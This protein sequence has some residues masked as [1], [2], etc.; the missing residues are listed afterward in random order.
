MTPDSSPP[1][2]ELLR[3][4]RRAAGLTQ[5]ELAERAGLSWRGINDLER[6]VRQTPRKDTVALLAAALGL[7][8][9]ERTAFEVAARRG[10][11]RAA[12]APSPTSPP[13]AVTDESAAPALPTGTVTFLFTDIEGST[14]LLQQLGSERY[15][16][17]EA[18]HH[19]V[20][21]AACAAHSGREV[22]TAGDSFFVAFARAAEAVAVA[23]QAQR[24]LA[25]HAWPEGAA[26]RVRMGLH[27][28]API[29][30][31][32]NYVGLDVH[33]AARIAAAGHGGQVLLSQTTRDLVEA[34]LPEGA[35]LRDLGAHRLK[36]L[37]RP[38]QLSQLVLPDLPADFPPLNALD[39]H[40]HNLPVQLTS[41][42]GRER[43]LAEL[44]PLLLA[45]RLL[46]LTG[47]GGTGKT[48]LALSLAADVLERFADGVWLVEL[49]PLADP[50]LVPHSVA[51]TL[52]V[53]EQ[54]G[55]PILET[56]LDALRP[57]TLLLL[58]DNCE[59]LI[60]T[61][62]QMAETLLRAAPSVR[63]LASSR[64]ALGIAGETAYRV[65][66]LPLPDPVQPGHQRALDL[67]ALAQ[68]DCVRLFVERAAATY[69]SFRLT[70]TNAR[71]IAQIGRR[72]DGIP[73]A[74]ELAAART[75]VF[76]PNQIVARLDDR[77]RLLTGGSRTALPR[78]QTLLALI[79]WSHDLLSEAE[80][81]LL[82]RLSVFAGGWSLEAAQAVCGDGLGEDVL[83]MLANIAEKS[84]VEVDASLDA[85]EARYRFLET[86]RQ[87]ARDKLLA[88]GEAEQVR[89]RHLE[90]FVQFAEEAEPRLRGAEQLAWL[91]R[92]EQ[93]HDNLRTA[94]AWAVESGKRERALRLAGALYYFWEL[95][96]YWSEG[97][98]W[99]DDALALS[100]RQQRGPAAAGA[101]GESGI[102]TRGE[103]ALRAKALYGAARMHFGAQLDMADSRTLVE[104]SLRLWREL[105]DKWWTAVALEHIAFVLFA[106]D[107][108]TSTARVEEGVSLAREVEDRW[109]LA[110]CL[111]RLAYAVA[112]T[113]V[114]AAWR[115]LEEWV[116][117]ARGVGDKSVLSMGLGGMAPFY[118]LEGNLAAAASAA[119]EALG[120]ARAIGSVVQVFLSLFMLIFTACLQGDLATA[121]EY[122]V[123]VVAYTRETGA[124]QWLLLGLL[125]FGTVACFGGQAE[126][127]VRLL[128][129][130]ETPMR[131]RGLDPSKLGPGFMVIGQALERARAQLGPAFEL[132][133]AEGQQMTLEQA[134]ALAT[135]D[136]S[137]D[138]PLPE[139]S[140]GPDTD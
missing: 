37:Q 10:M 89:D 125:G 49:A 91:E 2:G 69:I 31:G 23:A 24:A 44:T 42:V 79:D 60:A 56:L 15:A 12:P 114:A 51:A 3:R 59:H 93:E 74:L 54:P 106:E 17:L 127:G 75:R 108:Q 132:A 137:V 66:S 117:V 78:H 90:Y 77:F 64:E 45:S 100:A 70:A 6:G 36:D 96:G 43:E 52:G 9:E 126:R 130:A 124:S 7:S 20:V 4:S 21:R 134:L 33:R 105:D 135:D 32:D 61:C 55:Q 67:A 80:R 111:M 27:T 34:D 57:K 115:I 103:A 107:I 102:P 35:A 71:A 94:L 38:E 25:T 46:T 50:T 110:L 81:V 76:P 72:L 87:Y 86:I 18:E 97:Q 83:E 63:I 1:F 13:P 11:G 113:D 28:G 99:V 22:D 129:S 131:Q 139:A 5:A 138:A 29:V 73:L 136:D 40:R 39:R 112:V 133:W 65:P 26:V 30:A 16:A 41:F 104:E 48:R 85:T 88:S 82:R 84:L 8:G 68:N 14:R 118:W 101:V 123:Q 120:E 140:C 128:A 92:I 19:R 121:R 109:P 119:E 62:A 122:C 95:R 53:R 58:L 98:R 47:P 116:A